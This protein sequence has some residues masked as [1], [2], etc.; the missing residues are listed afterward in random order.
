MKKTLLTLLLAIFYAS[1][2]YAQCT[3][4][5]TL[6]EVVVPPFGSKIDSVNQAVIFPYAYVN[7]PYSEVIYFRIP[8]DTFFAAVNDTIPINYVK[9]DAL[10]GL[11]ATMTLSCVPSNCTFPGGSFGC[12]VMQGTP[13]TKDSISLGVAIEYNISI[14]GLPT[15]IKD[16]LR[17]YYI[18]VKDAPISIEE[19][20][21]KSS[22]VRIYPNPIKDRLFLSFNSESG[23][24]AELKIHSIIGTQVYHGKYNTQYGSNK[25]ELN[26]AKLNSG[27]YLYSLS[28][29]DKNYTGRFTVSH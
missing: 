21:K 12:A 28:I 19:V 13:T 22:D 6:T 17:G 23:K 26:T 7:Q 9:L 29:G 27:I 8:T 1:S 4:D 18:V 2:G 25:V 15:P 14:S 16:T 5:T 10:I 11:P 20:A 3:P 24:S